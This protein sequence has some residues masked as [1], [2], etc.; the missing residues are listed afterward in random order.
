MYLSW[1]VSLL[2]QEMHEKARFDPIR[3]NKA[4]SWVS[5]VFTIYPD[6]SLE[7][8]PR[9]LHAHTQITCTHMAGS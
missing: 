1:E 8:S 5:L 7:L 2:K 9:L 3:I 4:T 6:V